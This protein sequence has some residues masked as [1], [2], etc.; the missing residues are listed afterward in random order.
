MYIFS[1]HPKGHD[2]ESNYFQYQLFCK[3]LLVFV[4][5]GLCNPTT[6]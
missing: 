1:F 6:T 3:A 4:V 5:V 2:E